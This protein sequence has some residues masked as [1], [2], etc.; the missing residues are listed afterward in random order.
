MRY[1]FVA[2]L[3][4]FLGNSL[5]AQ[6]TRKSWLVELKDPQISI[7][8]IAREYEYV[9]EVWPEIGLW[10]VGAKVET[11]EI[12]SNIESFWTHNPFIERVY[13]NKQVNKR[14]TAN[15]PFYGNQPYYG[16]IGLE[17][18]W[19]YLKGGVNV[20]GD[21]IVVAYIDD[22][23]DTSHPD[24]TP[25]LFRNFKETPWNGVDDDNNGYVDDYWGW[26]SGEQSALVF[27]PSS[28]IDGHGT[29]VAGMIGAKG[30]NG[31]GIAG[32]HW[33]VKV[34]PINTYPDD[35]MNVESA[36]LR[37]MLYV[38]KQ[39]QLYLNSNK[40][41][42]INIV[43]L[44]M[45]LGMDNAFPEDAPYWCS[46]YDSL[47]S[48]GIWSYNAT[49][50]RNIDVGKQGDIPTLCP[51]RFLISVNSSTLNDAHYSSGFSDSFIDLA[52]PGVNL[53][54]TIPMSFNAT[55]PYATE[56]G[57]SY[58]S[59]IVAG[60]SAIMD[61]LACETYVLLKEQNPDSAI[62]LWRKWLSTTVKK[63]SS[64]ESKTQWGGR[65]DATA[66]FEEMVS[67][68]KVND[69]KYNGARDVEST[70]SVKI[71][72]NPSLGNLKIDCGEEGRITIFDAAGR[73]F[74]E[75]EVV[76]GS[77]EFNFEGLQG[78]FFVLFEGRTL[79]LQKKVHFF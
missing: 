30:N 74:G 31:L 6:T 43:A 56:T 45:S 18:V 37:G 26:N 79:R 70:L 59:P 76:E 55:K 73:N 67:W 32:T 2:V 41:Q 21:T 28:V 53:Y 46:L 60:I 62:V 36:V 10:E 52:A 47:G 72:P 20:F 17:Y 65:I 24:L 15:D 22:G 35:L 75:F 4:C 29:N 63:S 13:E 12:S 9:K 78:V 48:V 8:E 16:H 23:A 49:T 42:G 50:N 5:R 19:N 14:V 71:Y 66:L 33:Q 25:N 61:E 69:P 51:S 64:L 57:T 38:F 40:T 11:L 3:F 27:S 7:Y 34:L 39:K 58:A 77:N 68:C 54:T 1:L 44:N